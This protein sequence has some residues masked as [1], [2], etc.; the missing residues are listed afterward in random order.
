M[1]R[2][3][4]VS[5]LTTSAVASVDSIGRRADA[6]FGGW[7]FQLRWKKPKQSLPQ[8][9][10]V[11]VAYMFCRALHTLLVNEVNV[12]QG[13]LF[14]GENFEQ[15]IFSQKLVCGSDRIIPRIK[16][17]AGAV[18]LDSALLN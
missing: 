12:T 18:L 7:E 11:G 16:N 14:V 5:R 17:I 6:Y 2:T 10:A 3:R 8:S 13:W 15:D 9:L 4:G 1:R